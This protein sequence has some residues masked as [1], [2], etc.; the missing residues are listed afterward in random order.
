MDIVDW[1]YEFVG[2]IFFLC[3]FLIFVDL[4][5][6]KVFVCFFVFFGGYVVI[7]LLFVVFFLGDE[8]GVCWLV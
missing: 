3:C 6:K 1:F 4:I 8:F 5:N 7:R 2:G